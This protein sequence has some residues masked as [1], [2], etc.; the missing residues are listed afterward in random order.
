MTPYIG[1]VKTRTTNILYL[2]SSIMCVEERSKFFKNMKK[3]KRKIKCQPNSLQCE[4]H[5]FGSWTP[6][7]VQTHSLHHF[8]LSIYL[9]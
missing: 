3:M 5:I 7:C 1:M 9:M 8:F 2:C 6:Q 4:F